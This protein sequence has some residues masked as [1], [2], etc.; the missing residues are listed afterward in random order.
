[1]LLRVR[2]QRE[3]LLRCELRRVVVETGGAVELAPRPFYPAGERGAAASFERACQHARDVYQ[4]ITG[5]V[6]Q[7]I[8][9][10]GLSQK[11]ANGFV[12]VT[13]QCFEIGPAQSA[14]R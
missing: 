10:I 1:M 6:A 13:A 11:L 8:E 3:K 2:K 7:A 12:G 14:P 4:P 5:V 9:T